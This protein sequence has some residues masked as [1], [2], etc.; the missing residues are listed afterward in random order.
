MSLFKNMLS[1]NESLFVNRVALDYDYQP[2]LVPYREQHQHKMAMCIKPLFEKANGRNLFMFGPPGIGKTVACKHVLLDLDEQTDEILHFYINCWQ[3]N[4]SYKIFVHLCEQLGQRFIQNKKTDEL[5]RIIKQ[6]LNKKS[7]VFVFDEVDKLE[8]VSFLY[9][10]L[11]EIYRKSI[12]LITNYREWMNSLDERIKSRLI[13][14]SL[15]FKPYSEA[16]TKGILKE[17]ISYA[18]APSV[19]KDDAFSL[20][21]DKTFKIKDIRTGMYLLRES[22]QAAEDESSR[23]VEVSHVKK[24]LLKLDEFSVNDSD[25]LSDD[26]NF[27]LDIVKQN[28]GSKIGDL[29]R[30]YE[31]KGGNR[32]YK[33]FQRRISKLEQGKFV[34]C[35]KVQG[36]EGNTTIVSYVGDEVK[37]LSDF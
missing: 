17:R 15:E 18:F 25:D 31:S 22:G 2:K 9:S 24:A 33:Y 13:P 34:S 37:R 19:W 36:K 14:E 30:I 11:E 29:F 27:I 16:E 7:V 21:S 32:G 28:S 10:I 12:F 35:V 3:L 20:V 5:F 8:D 6:I 23:T 4:S 1:S 26:S